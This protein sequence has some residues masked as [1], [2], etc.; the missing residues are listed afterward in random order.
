MLLPTLLYALFSLLSGAG[1][2]LILTHSRNRSAGVLGA[3]ITL[4]LF[5]ALYAGL[6]ALLREGGY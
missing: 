6:V 1:V 5:A 3:F 2:F 4:T